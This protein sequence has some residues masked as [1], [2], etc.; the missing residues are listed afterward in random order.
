MKI[1]MNN[2]DSIINYI[3]EGD[4]FIVT[5]HISPDGDNIGSTLSMYYTLK[6]LGKNV[7]YV[8]DDEAPLNLRFLVED[9]KIYKSNEFNM[10]NYSLIALDCGDKMRICVSD[11]IKN[12][13][14]K[15]ICIDHHA[16]NDSYG[17][18]NYVDIDASSTCEL[19]YNLL[20]RFQQIKDINIINE[21]I[22]TCLYTG[23]V[24]DT[25]NFSYSNVHASSFEM[26]K[27]L[28]VLGAQ[29]NTIIQNI[30]QSNSSG[31][32]KLLGE[33]LKG[34][35]IFDSKVSSVVLTQDMMN[36]NN[37]SFNDVDG[38]TTYTR[39][40]KG[41]EVGILFKEKKQNEIKVSFRSKNYVDVSEI[42]KLF[43]GGGH[44]R[45]AGC[46][47][48]DS[49]DNAKKMVLEAVLKSI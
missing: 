19:V 28:L 10:K 37:I 22:A 6:N 36:R 32:Y 18:L 38:I 7:Y 27:N 5:S 41:I 48:R 29:K 39:D 8:L 21:D 23:L 42:A 16:S 49:I 44:V 9:V 2:M 11:E 34:L 30:Y 12:N 24:T 20:V 47:I 17:D 1:M 25:G 45:A 46:T 31:Y 43:G 13:A 40:I 15:L 4:Y 14:S 35:E 33:A 3:Y 26:A